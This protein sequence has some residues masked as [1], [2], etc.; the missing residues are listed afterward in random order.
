MQLLYADWAASGLAVSLTETYIQEE[1]LPC[2][3]HEYSH[4][5]GLQSTCFPVEGRLVSSSCDLITRSSTIM[6]AV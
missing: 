4:D 2:M 3:V 1:V 6:I 5:V